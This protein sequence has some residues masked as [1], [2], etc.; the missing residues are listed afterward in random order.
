[1]ARVVHDNMATTQRY[2]DVYSA[3][4]SAAVEIGLVI[5]SI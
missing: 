1:M 5:Q 2:I 4:I 3:M